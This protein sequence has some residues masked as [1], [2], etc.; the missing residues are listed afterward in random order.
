MLRDANPVVRALF[1]D[2]LDEKLVFLG[3]PRTTAM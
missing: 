2:Q 1:T 3:N